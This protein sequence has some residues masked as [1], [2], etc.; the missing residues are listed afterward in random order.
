MITKTDKGSKLP[1]IADPR[2]EA[3]ITDPSDPTGKKAIQ[4]GRQYVDET[5]YSGSY[6]KLD[7]PENALSYKLKSVDEDSPEASEHY[8]RTHHAINQHHFWTGTKEEFKLQF[9]KN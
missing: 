4:V 6:H 7:E 1:P 5:G 2:P 9:E 8:G 3:F